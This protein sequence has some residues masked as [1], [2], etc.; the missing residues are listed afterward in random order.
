M[1]PGS[2][3]FCPDCDALVKLPAEVPAGGKTTCPECKAVFHVPEEEEMNDRPRRR[4]RSAPSGM[5]PVVLLLILAPVLLGI[6]GVVAGGGWLAWK[7]A[8]AN[9][10]DAKATAFQ[11][12][13]NA[14]AGLLPLGGNQPPPLGGNQAPPAGGIQVGAVAPEIE[15]EDLDGN[16]FKLSDYRGKVVILDFWGHW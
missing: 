11:A 5:K 3:C 14:P 15:G 16:R 10:E 6:I 8:Q 12:S 1:M 2:R 13:T 4:Q 7:V 9:K